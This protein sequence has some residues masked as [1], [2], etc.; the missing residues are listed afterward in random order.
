MLAS[1][2]KLKVSKQFF[3]IK[4]IPIHA[5][6]VLVLQYAFGYGCSVGH[7]GFGQNDEWFSN[8]DNPPSYCDF[9]SLQNRW[10][11]HKEFL[12]R[13][14]VPLYQHIFLTFP[15]ICL[16]TA[17]FSAIQISQAISKSVN[18]HLV[19]VCNWLAVNKL[20]LNVK[21]PQYTLFHPT[22]TN[23]EGLLPE[24]K[25]NVISIISW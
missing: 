11:L 6:T 21:N 13:R 2:H 22:N 4:G 5:K 17:L 16:V 15:Q 1:C 19:D 14:F 20:S 9:I 10:V 12:D 25:V 23:I 8:C 3:L 24:I 18:N 7:I